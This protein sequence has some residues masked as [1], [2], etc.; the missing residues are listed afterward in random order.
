VASNPIGIPPLRYETPLT[1]ADK[2][3]PDAHRSLLQ[4]YNA[5]QLIKVSTAA[6]PQK[7]AVP[8]SAKN[9]GVEI[10]YVK[11]SNDAHTF[12]LVGSGDDEINFGTPVVSG[13]NQG[14]KVKIR[15]D[16]VSSWYVTG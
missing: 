15:A 4:L 6:G 1:A 12:T 13:A 8:Y 3:T 14:A 10:T 11:T 7:V 9:Q 5:N 2:V 16:G